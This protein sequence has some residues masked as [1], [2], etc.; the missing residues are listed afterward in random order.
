KKTMYHGDCTRTV[1]N[2]NIPN[3][4]VS[5]HSAVVEAK[6]AATCATKAGVSGETVH[7]ETIR[8]LNERGYEEGLPKE[9]DP[10]TFCSMPHG[11]GHGIGLDV[12]EPPLLDRNGAVLIVG[13]VVTIEPGL[14]SHALGGVRI[15]DM[16]VVTEDGCENFNT[17]HE[18]LDWC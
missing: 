7:L 4:I 14:Y 2:G 12:H 13:D 10:P 5:M 6:K 11:T 3:E 15:E 18:G 17:L 16:V 1:V 9:T 8:V